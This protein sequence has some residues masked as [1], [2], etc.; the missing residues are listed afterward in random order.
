MTQ[1]DVGRA[2]PRSGGWVTR[3][4]SDPF[5]GLVAFPD[6]HTAFPAHLGRCHDLRYRGRRGGSAT[7]TTPDRIRREPDAAHPERFGHL[8][9]QCRHG[10]PGDLS[11]PGSVEQA[12]Q[13]GCV[14]RSAA[15]R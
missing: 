2:G 14:P 13:A 7:W 11:A 15:M 3:A 6:F 4:R 5:T 8:I 10:P 9:E 1:L 12:F